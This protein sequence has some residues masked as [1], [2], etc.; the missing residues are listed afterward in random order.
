M[1]L[2]IS[3]HTEGLFMN[4]TCWKPPI[5]WKSKCAKLESLHYQQMTSKS[6]ILCI[7]S[8]GSILVGSNEGSQS[9]IIRSL[10]KN[11]NLK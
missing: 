10:I 6:L 11:K 4:A 5:Y 2:S 7:K 9:S 3:E 1:R 8:Q